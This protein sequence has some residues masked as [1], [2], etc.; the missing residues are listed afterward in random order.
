MLTAWP[1]IEEKKIFFLLYY[2]QNNVREHDHTFQSQKFCTV[3]ENKLDNFLNCTN[4]NIKN[5]WKILT[6]I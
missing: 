4:Y 2:K 6:E 5:T 3:N 1:E